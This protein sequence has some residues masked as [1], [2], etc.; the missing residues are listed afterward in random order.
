MEAQR[1]RRNRTPGHVANASRFE[2]RGTANQVRCEVFAGRI[3]GA[4]KLQAK[5]DHVKNRL[6]HPF[7]IRAGEEIYEV[8]LAQII[9]EQMELIREIVREEIQDALKASNGC[10]RE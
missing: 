3:A 9:D 4:G 10:S 8:V 1:V 2:Y 5:G 7:G 6:H